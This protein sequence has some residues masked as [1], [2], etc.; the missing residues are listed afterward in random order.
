VIS[1]TY[2]A[3]LA[4]HRLGVHD[5]PCPVCGPERRSPINRRRKVL[6]LWCLSPEFISYRCARCD[7]HGYVRGNDDV[8]ALD[9]AML[10]QVRAE[11]QRF[12]RATAEAK[13]QKALWLWKQRRPIN[14]TVAERYLRDARG[15]GGPLPTTL[16]FLPARG[17][18]A[19]AMIAAFGI[20]AELEPGV[21][22]V[23]EVQGVHL[24]RLAANGLSKAGT[25]TD[26]IM[27][28]T[29]RGA[30]VALAAIGDSLALLIAEGI[31]D[32]LSGH[33]AV[34]TGA[35]AAGSASFLPAL[36]AAVPA[37][38]ESVTVL[39]DDDQDGRRHADEL[40]RQIE[41]RH[42]EVRLVIPNLWEHAGS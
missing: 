25:H 8:P 3:H 41:H 21:I 27:I 36:A 38:V 10:A 2:L 29:P 13:R 14:G 7:V 34:G 20:P 33:E 18:H 12:A 11:A 24:T 15:Y 35:W 6:R 16:A 19:P 9:P 40:A 1:F 31:E 5:V 30:P 32:S 17:D 28:G 42:I 4:D 37:C 22:N 39:V 26:K 23:S